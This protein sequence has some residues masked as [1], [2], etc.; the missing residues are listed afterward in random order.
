MNFIQAVVFSLVF[1]GVWSL[2]DFFTMKGEKH[3]LLLGVGLIFVI[4]AWVIFTAAYSI[5]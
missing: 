2:K 4:A 3:F 5:R 1:F